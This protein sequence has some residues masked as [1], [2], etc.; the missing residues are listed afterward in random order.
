MCAPGVRH[1]LSV[2]HP[3]AR[4]DRRA[5]E[6]PAGFRGVFTSDEDARAT[7]SRASGPFASMPLA[8]AFP[9]GTDDVVALVLWARAEGLTL[10]PRGAGTGMPGGNVGPGVVVDLTALAHVSVADRDAGVVEAGAGAT[11]D[12]LAMAAAALGRFVPPLPSSS[13][14]CTAG[15]MVA[16]NAAGARSFGHGAVH[17]W[18]E[19][20]EVVLPDGSVHVVGSADT[21]PAYDGLAE[22]LEARLGPAGLQ[23]W[24]RVGKNASGYALDRFLASRSPLDLLVG[25]EGT[26]GVVTRVWFRTA[27]EP[28]G[29]GLALLPLPVGAPIDPAV[30]QVAAMGAVTCEFFGDRFLEVAGLRADRELASLVS[31]HPALL[32]VELEGAGGPADLSPVQA[33]A[34]SLGVTA[35]V[36]HT[37]EERDRIWAVRHA[38]SPVVAAK[39]SQGLVS[40]QFIEDSVV[41]QGRLGAYVECLGRILESAETDAV[42]FGHAGDA[43]VHVNPLVDIR[44]GD[45]RDRVERILDET[46]A[47]VAALGGTLSGEHGDGRLRAPFHP[48]VFGGDL[49]AAFAAVK[50]SLDPTGVLN[51]GVVVPLPGQDPLAGLTS[52][53]RA[54]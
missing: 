2:P 3:P 28:A 30:A 21:L 37:P 7:A 51:P 10:I 6:P 9:Q 40:M 53:R 38:A 1:R 27:A 14:R 35:W 22:A 34:S 25:S 24:P 54:E 23:G 39:A 20:L 4:S 33:L 29:R 42:I 11:G 18:V 41:P 19:A 45:W 44:R 48:R 31:S 47:L 52:L 49:A 17:R 13:R 46:V 16:N 15:G 12:A 36:G 50:A 5:P 32:L 8:V 26:L 43:N